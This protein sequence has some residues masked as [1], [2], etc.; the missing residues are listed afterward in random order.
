MEKTSTT[1][2]GARKNVTL[3]RLVLTHN[4]QQCWHTP[5]HA[6]GNNVDALAHTTGNN[7]GTLLHTQQATMWTHSCTHNR[8]QCGHTPAHTT[9]NN[10]LCVQVRE[11]LLCD[12][13][14]LECYP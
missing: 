12:M 14:Y 8:Q 5:A 1:A 13:H 3:T 6:T 9:G 10:V 2:S 7:I 4:R 11:K